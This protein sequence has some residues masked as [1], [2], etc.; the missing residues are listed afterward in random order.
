[1]EH[2]E[3]RRVIGDPAALLDSAWRN[4]ADPDGISAGIMTAFIDAPY[5]IYLLMKK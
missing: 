5:F 4:L 2:I 3:S 1:M